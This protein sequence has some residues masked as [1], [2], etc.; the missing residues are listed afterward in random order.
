[1]RDGGRDSR[2]RSAGVAGGCLFT[3]VVR[4]PNP[5]KIIDRAF[6]YKE[7][8]RWQPSVISSWISWVPEALSS[9]STTV[10]SKRLLNRALRGWANYF[11]VAE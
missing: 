4:R 8:P 3:Q 7:A 11:C 10:A 9:I 2:L 5:R 6:F 1:V